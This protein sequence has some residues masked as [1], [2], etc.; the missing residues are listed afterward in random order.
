MSDKQEI[1]IKEGFFLPC[2]VG[3]HDL[4]VRKYSDFEMMSPRNV[5]HGY[6]AVDS[7]DQS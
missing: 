5:V 7:H 1:V 6:L 2:S 4:G 3:K